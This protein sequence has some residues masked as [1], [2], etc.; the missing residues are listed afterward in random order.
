M[1]RILLVDDDLYLRDVYK[2]VLTEVGNEVEIAEDG[3]AGLEKILEGGYDLILLDIMMP[4]LDGIGVLSIL[5]DKK[6]KKKNGPI[7]ILTNLAQ[8]LI[9]EEAMENGAFVCLNKA[10][11][12]PDQLLIKVKELLK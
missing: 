10:S 4:Y 12:N 11:L 2:E 8:D 6:P 5:R 3:K 1:K 9:A 7:V